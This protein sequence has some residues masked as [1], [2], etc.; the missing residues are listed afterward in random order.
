MAS[1][2]LKVRRAETPAYRLLK[3]VASTLLTARMPI[4]SPLRMFVRTL[5]TLHFALRRLLRRVYMFVYGEPLFRSRCEK[6]GRGSFVWA[7]PEVNGHT[8]IHVGNQVSIWEISAS[9]AG[10]RLTSPL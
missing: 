2:F 9:R 5:Y 1:I 7:V 4:P 10:E 3:R 6:L 8:R